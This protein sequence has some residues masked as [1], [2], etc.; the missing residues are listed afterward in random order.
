M[1]WSRNYRNQN[2]RAPVAN[3][4]SMHVPNDCLRML[5]VRPPVNLEER[6]SIVKEGRE[7]ETSHGLE[8]QRFY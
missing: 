8:L 2:A 5:R 3:T 7:K 1:I 4:R 6:I